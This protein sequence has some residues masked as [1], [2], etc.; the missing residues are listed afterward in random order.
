MKLDYRKLGY[1]T[2][3]PMTT[4]ERDALKSPPPLYL[5][6]FNTTVQEFQ[7]HVGNDQWLSLGLIAGSKNEG[8][9]FIWSAVN[10]ALQALSEITNALHGTRGSGL[11]GDSHVA[12]TVSG[13]PNYITLSGQDIVRGLVDLLTDVVNDL[14]IAEGGTGQSTAQ[15]AIDALTAVSGATDEHVL[16]KDTAS[17]NAIFKAAGGGGGAPTDAPYL[18]LGLD[19]GLSAEISVLEAD[20]STLPDDDLHWKWNSASDRLTL[21][22]NIGAGR[23]ELQVKGHAAL[24]GNSVSPG[25]SEILIL[26]ETVSLGFL[27]SLDLI[28]AVGIYQGTETFTFQT[29]F[30]GEVKNQ[31]GSG[32][33]VAGMRGLSFK[34]K[35]EGA[36]TVTLMEGLLATTE[37]TSAGTGA[38]TE[39]NI[40]RLEHKQNASGDTPATQRG[41]HIRTSGAAGLRSLAGTTTIGIQVDNF[42]NAGAGTDYL[43]RLGSS[44]VI[45]RV[46]EGTPGANKTGLFLTEGATP[47]LRQV[48]WK[49]GPTVAGDKVLVL[50]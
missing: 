23:A 20:E 14:P 25:D 24:G 30:R 16:T 11:H 26:R 37:I 50:V 33:S 9:L 18:T 13:T 6:I 47:T 1:F 49:A 22:E 41:I 38:V 44:T 46:D 2:L 17:G 35:H 8:D 36:A 19:A 40:A 21:I 32:G 27:G 12:I 7:I 3:E 28:D 43:M 39:M 31:M 29:G 34:A 42:N 15:A 48:R 5:V 10:S 4:A 45:A